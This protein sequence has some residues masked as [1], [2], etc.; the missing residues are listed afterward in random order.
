MEQE[1]PRVGALINRA[2][3]LLIRLGDSQLR[4]LGLAGAQIPVLMMLKNGAL[5]TQKQ[6]ADMTR[7][8]QPSMAQTLSRMERDGLIERQTDPN[9]RRSSLIRLTPLAKSK[10][11]AA[12]KVMKKGAT[13]VFAGI[14]E[15]ELT[16][17]IGLLQRVVGNLEEQ[18]DQV[19]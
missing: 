19:D 12:S 6:M 13:H 3:R 16:V 14:D 4:P 17:L 7:I 2:S 18:L 8:E 11:P 10:L 1:R 15:H 9:D 5:L